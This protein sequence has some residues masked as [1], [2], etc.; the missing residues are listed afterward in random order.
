MSTTTLQQLLSDLGTPVAAPLRG[1]GGV[2]PKYIEKLA[3]ACDWAADHPDTPQAGNVKLASLQPTTVSDPRAAADARGASLRE[4]L[5]AQLQQKILNK[6]ASAQT[7]RVQLDQNAINA[8]VAKLQ[9]R[10][11]LAKTASVA[12]AVAAPVAIEDAPGS[13]QARLR[14][15]LLAK[16]Q[17]LQA[18]ARQTP[19]GEVAAAIEALTPVVEDDGPDSANTY[20]NEPDA[21]VEHTAPA[22]D[23]GNHAPVKAA[24]VGFSSAGSNGGDS[25][26]DVVR[27]AL[28][29]NGPGVSAEATPGNLG[30]DGVKTA[31]ARGKGTANRSE[32]TEALRQR[33]LAHR[34]GKEIG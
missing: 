8:V 11:D 13:L 24:S 2:D 29:A 4:A 30:G 5:A 26:A 34:A 20:Q 19:E 17:E 32:A 3:S 14:A 15:G 9:A 31:G 22:L 10:R 16:Q 25:L 7:A 27:A 23:A 18:A 12:A 1:A 28:Q 33:V 6:H 21:Q